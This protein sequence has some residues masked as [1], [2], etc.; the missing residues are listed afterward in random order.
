M[1]DMTSELSERD[2][3]DLC[4]FAD[5]TLPAERREEIQARVAASPR[6]LEL[7][8]RQRRSLA[9]TTA[10]AAEPVPGS[11][12]EVLQARSRARVS[13]GRGR[14]RLALLLSAAGVMA[15]VVVA[16]LV[17]DLSSKTPAPSVADAARFALAPPAGPPPAAVAGTQ[18]LAA[19]VQE[20]PFPDLSR[21]FGWRAV[22][23]R[24]GRLGGRDATTVYY[25]RGA[26]RVGYVI[27]AGPALPLPGSATS[28]TLSGV[29]F[30]GLSVGGRPMITWRRH[31]HTCVMIGDVSRAQLL[32]LASWRGGGS[33]DYSG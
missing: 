30:Q 22:G 14:R 31:G 12:S 6:L 29:R 8:E 20:L 2:M 7:V 3:A 9:A 23:V 4:A 19:S 28:T 24:R 32:T 25:A 1:D 5:G 21:A 16:F 27:V 10:L 17:I 18:R 11:L 13:A 15:A 26:H 33:M